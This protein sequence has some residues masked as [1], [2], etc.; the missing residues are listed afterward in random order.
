MDADGGHKSF[1]SGNQ[2]LLSTFLITRNAGFERSTGGSGGAPDLKPAQ[3]LLV[4]DLGADHLIS[5]AQAI[6]T[7]DRGFQRNTKT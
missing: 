2:S 4:E 3:C 6:S 1:K 7:S 5:P